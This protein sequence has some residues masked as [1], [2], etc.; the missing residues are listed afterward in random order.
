MSKPHYLSVD[1]ENYTKANNSY[2][3][4]LMAFSQGANISLKELFNP[5]NLKIQLYL[6]KVDFNNRKIFPRINFI[7]NNGNNSNRF[8][9]YDFTVSS[10]ENEINLNVLEP[11]KN[12]NPQ[13]IGI[14]TLCSIKDLCICNRLHY[15]FLN[16]SIYVILPPIDN[17]PLD[18]IVNNNNNN[19]NN[20]NSNVNYITI[21]HPN[22]ED[23]EKGLE[24]GNYNFLNVSDLYFHSFN[25]Q[26]QD[27]NRQVPVIKFVYP[28]EIVS[29]NNTIQVKQK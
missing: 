23:L 7:S 6:N 19:N 12:D 18:L 4:K 26:E 2:C 1:L 13:M 8:E 25:V 10:N 21:V 16:H 29:H 3:T 14:K 28:F 24:L 20:N 22:E 11:L 17:K 5:P 27:L 15:Y 9:D